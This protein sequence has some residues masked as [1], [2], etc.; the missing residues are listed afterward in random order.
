M[1]LHGGSLIAATLASLIL[2]ATAVHAQTPISVAT[3]T[4][5]VNAITTVDNN[6]GTSYSINFQ[7]SIT[8]NSGTTLPAINTT[9][10]LIINGGSFTLDGGND[11]QRGFFVYSGSV[12][13]NN[14]TIQNTQALGG[15]GGVSG[16]GGG[17]GLGGAL[18][19]ASGGGRHR[20]VHFCQ[21]GRSTEDSV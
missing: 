17:A 19:V 1:R 2:V 14:L 10:A 18:F 12:A 15:S 6:P 20:L 7:N 21:N 5:L 3:A 13:I 4:D 16:G 8:L 11:S 9:S